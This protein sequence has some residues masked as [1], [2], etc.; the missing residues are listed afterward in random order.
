MKRTFREDYRVRAVIIADSPRE[1]GLQIDGVIV[2]G[3]VEV[4]VAPERLGDLGF[5]RVSDSM[6]SNDVERDYR[7]RAEEMAATLRRQSH[8]IAATVEF[9]ERSECSHC[10]YAWDELTTT[11]YVRTPSFDEGPGMPLCCEEAQAEWRAKCGPKGRLSGFKTADRRELLLSVIL[12]ERGEW[13][14]HRVKRVYSSWKLDHFYRSTIRRD[15]AA[16]HADQ[17]LTLHDSIGRRYFTVRG[18]AQ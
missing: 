6:V 16:L 15:L 7:L 4:V 11:D 17:H 1:L 18:G 14:P 9:T 3:R 8:I 5:V 12:R 10:G 13:T 2:S